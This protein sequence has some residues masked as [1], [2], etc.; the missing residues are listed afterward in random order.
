MARFSEDSPVTHRSRRHW[1]W[2]SWPLFV[3]ILGLSVAGVWATQVAQAQNPEPATADQECLSCHSKPDLSM[4]LSNGD[5]LSLYISPDALAQ[6]VHSPLG[7]GCQSCHPTLTGYPHPANQYAS[8]RE[9]SRAY[10]ESC[11]KCHSA[12][13]DQTR[14][15]LHNVHAQ[16]NASGELKTAICTDCHGAHDI[17]KIANDRVRITQTCGKCHQDIFTQYQS[18]VHG[19]ALLQEDNH[20]VPVCTDCHGVHSIQDPRLAQFRTASPEMCAGCHANSQLMSKYGLTTDVYNLYNLSWHGVDVSV[21]KANWPTIWHDSA[22]CTDCHGVHNIR[23]TTDAASTVNPANL[24]TTCQRCHPGAGPNWTGTWTGHNRVSLT[25]TPFIFST[26]AFYDF[27]VM[28]VLGA[29]VIYVGLQII[30]ATV[31]RVRRSL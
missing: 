12:N 3:V 23:K 27:F 9:L 6:S 20:D 2:Q 16:V 10:Y 30:R 5:K 11:Q 4:T 1:L 18:S 26:Q 21:Y 28:L 25:R 17:R 13:Y 29:S 7:I 24:L 14:D 31:A 15:T 22:V 19:T 8:A